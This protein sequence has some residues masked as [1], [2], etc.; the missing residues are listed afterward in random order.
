MRNFRAS[1]LDEGL[2]RALWASLPAPEPLARREVVV[3]GPKVRSAKA[4]PSCRGSDALILEVRRLYEYE[5]MRPAGISRI[6]GLNPRRIDQIV[7]YVTRAHLV[8]ERRSEP[9]W[10]E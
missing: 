9:Y 1:V 8:P 3:H 4:H 7:K 2:E 10:P 6:T 5:G